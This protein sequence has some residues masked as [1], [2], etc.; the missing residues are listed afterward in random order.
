M[1]ADAEMLADEGTCV[2]EVCVV[3]LDDLLT[4]EYHH[5]SNDESRKKRRSNPR[6]KLVGTTQEGDR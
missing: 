4:S 1:S 6:T 3:E 5:Q 2:T